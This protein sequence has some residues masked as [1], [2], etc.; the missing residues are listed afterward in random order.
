MFESQPSQTTLEAALC[1]A[2][3]Q[4]DKAQKLHYADML[5]A[6]GLQGAVVDQCLVAAARPGFEA[7]ELI[8]SLLTR[9]SVNFNEGEAL[10]H[11]IQNQEEAAFRLI[12]A[13][14]PDELAI[15]S[16]L[17]AALAL[18][19]VER[20]TFYIELLPQLREGHLDRA[21]HHLVDGPTPDL[22]LLGE[23]LEA[24]PPL[25]RASRAIASAVHAGHIDD[26]LLLIIEVFATEK[27]E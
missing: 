16:A 23:T 27:L 5:L 15:S 13:D 4:E 17:K 22:V 11:A 6:S 3:Q 8:E 20:R 24:G 18:P 12:L 1:V 10:R 9:A 21:L 19:K 25:E 14:R 7:T 2:I 26:Y